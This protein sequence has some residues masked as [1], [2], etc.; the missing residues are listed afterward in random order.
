MSAIVH[1]E[2]VRRVEDVRV[3]VVKGRAVVVVDALGRAVVGRDIVLAYD[4]GQR[5]E[6]G[7]SALAVQE[8]LPVPAVDRAVVAALSAG[9]EDDVMLD[10]V[11][12]H[13]AIVEVDRRARQVEHEVARDGGACGLGGKGGRRRPSAAFHRRGQ[14][15]RK[16]SP[17]CR[18][19]HRR[20]NRKRARPR[21][22]CNHR[23]HCTLAMKTGDDC[24]SWMPSSPDRIIRNQEQSEAT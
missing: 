18:G 15:T 6:G 3:D 23:N 16:G 12:A 22:L 10:E 17:R 11:A 9:V 20:C 8:G 14:S 21:W 19:N 5:A 1:L 24:F 4:D 7:R 2:A 13:R